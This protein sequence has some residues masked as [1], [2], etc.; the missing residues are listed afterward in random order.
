MGHTLSRAASPLASRTKNSKNHP[1][2]PFLVE[3]VFSRL[4]YLAQS[5]LVFPVSPVDGASRSKAKQSKATTS[6]ST[7]RSFVS[8]SLVYSPLVS[9]RVLSPLLLV[10]PLSLSPFRSK[11]L[12]PLLSPVRSLIS[13]RSRCRCRRSLL[14]PHALQLHTTSIRSL[15]SPHV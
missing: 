3:P 7:S 9:L 2:V 10:S 8:T 11:V 6:A 14:L 12:S 15:S 1:I 13:C 5:A 4:S